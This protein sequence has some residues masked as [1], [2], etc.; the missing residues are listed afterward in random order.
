MAKYEG[1][2]P[3]NVAMPNAS[4]IAVFNPNGNQVG[5][6]ALRGLKFPNAG[7]KLYSFGALSDVHYQED[8]APEDFQRAL[9]YLNETEDVAFTCICG[10]LTNNGTAAEL[11]AYKNAVDTYSP[12]TPVYAIMGNHDWRGGLANTIAN[13]T[14]HPTYYSIEHGNDVFIFVGTINDWTTDVLSTEELQWLY[15][16]LEANRNKRC[17]LFQ[18]IRPTKGCG[19]ALGI[20]KRDGIVDWGGTCGAVFESL[21]SHY[22]NIIFFHGHSHLKFYL[23]AYDE[24]ANYDNIRGSHSVHIP[25]LAVPRDTDWAAKPSEVRVYAD[26]EGY[27]VDVYENGVHLRGRDFVKEEF[28][29]IASYWLDTT[30]QEVEAGT[31][32]DGT[33]TIQT[34]TLIEYIETTKAQ[35]IDTG[36]KPDSNTR[37]IVDMALTS[38]GTNYAFGARSSSTS[39][40]FA[41]TTNA[42]EG[43]RLGY[44]S[45]FGSDVDH[46]KNRHIIEVNKNVLSL[47]GNVIVTATEREFD[48]AYSLCLGAVKAS[49]MYLGNT[50]FY[51]CKLYDNGTLIRDLVPCINSD[52]AVGMW[53][54]VNNKFY[55]NAG[56]GEF[57]TP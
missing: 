11:T 17:F 5:T 40:A 50:R 49:S 38:T 18:H 22:K 45:T 48:C 8:T 24:L 16:T 53:D 25:S 13:Y 33:G 51:S 34:Y 20:Y 7:E 14:G 41:L 44:Y 6:I 36:F 3:Q 26:S 54:K 12:D 1:F 47:D 10:D 32:T 37:I 46:D 4:K 43:W 35:Y 2:I 56:T 55:G 28:L 19:N 9:T 15:E 31:Y 30:I 57:I 52:G 23:Q 27:V 29:P 42:N 21:L 39:R